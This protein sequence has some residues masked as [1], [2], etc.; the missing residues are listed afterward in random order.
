MTPVIVDTGPLVALLNVRDAFHDWARETLDTIDPPLLTCEAVLAEASYL[1]RR[2]S[3]GP[4]AVL[5]L[6]TRGVLE[7]PLRIDSELLALR[8]LATKYASVPMSLADACL[9][10]MAELNPRAPVLTLDSDFR[11]YRR[12][13]RHALHLIIPDGR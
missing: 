13:G 7:V 1:V 6:V 10:R 5:D 11:T 9:V 4:E 2:L 12:S 3:G 8:T